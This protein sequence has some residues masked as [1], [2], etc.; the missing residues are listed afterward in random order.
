MKLM[1]A[2]PFK[3]LWAGRD[4]FDA[5][6]GLKGQVYRELEARRTL[7]TEVAGRGYFVKIHRGIG[8]GEIVKNLLTA[9][10]PVLGAGQEWRALERLH[11]VG[12]P[13]MTAVAYGE[14]GSNPAD[15]H[16]F[17][18]TEELAPTVSLEDFSI[19]WVKQPPAPA[20]KRALIAEVAR[21]TGMMHRAGV[22]HRDCYICHFLLH[23]DRPIT[24]ETLKL[25]VIDLH[26][27]QTR[28]KIT[29]RW[30]N[31]DLAAL[32]FSALDIGLTRRDKLRFLK[33]Y[34]QQPL[35]QILGEE[36]AL[37]SWLEGKAEK[38]YARK[39]RYGDAL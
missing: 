27:A 24:P 13:T 4:A 29:L 21:M 8:W 38:L 19:D 15:Q 7:R 22:N 39:Q 20:L 14:R 26:R 25:S 6:E 34:F 31:K 10:L 12:V 1:L 16:S 36:A 32:Y 28:P 35:R 23:T 17:I 3:S 18:V 5:V 30:R 9:K 37:L 2:E 33:G 11:Q